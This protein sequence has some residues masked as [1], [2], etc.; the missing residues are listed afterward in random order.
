MIVGSAKAMDFCTHTVM[1][2]TDFALPAREQG[3]WIKKTVSI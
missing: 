1:N 2:L 3:K